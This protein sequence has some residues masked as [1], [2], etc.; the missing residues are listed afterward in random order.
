MFLYAVK[1]RGIL[2]V[3]RSGLED[4]LFKISFYPGGALCQFIDFSRKVDRGV[5]LVKSQFIEYQKHVIEKIF[6][7]SKI[8]SIVVFKSSILYCHDIKMY[9]IEV[10]PGQLP[11]RLRR[12]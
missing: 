9:G 1:G 8:E 7:A 6:I 3:G 10:D 2:K 12:G 5:F 4:K 11:F